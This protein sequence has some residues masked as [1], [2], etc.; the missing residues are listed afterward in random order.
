[1]DGAP[2]GGGLRWLRAGY[3]AA[4]GSMLAAGGHLF[5]GG[6]LPGPG[7]LVALA[8]LV[9]WPLSLFLGRR[10][11]SRQ[12]LLLLLGAQCAMHVG[13]SLARWY[14]HA[15]SLAIVPVTHGT[16][17]HGGAAAAQVP[18]AWS[19]TGSMSHD[20][21][22]SIL[23]LAV[24]DLSQGH[25][26]TMVAAHLVGAA[27]MWWWLTRAEL[28]VFTLL[29]LSVQPAGIAVREVAGPL[30]VLLSLSRRAFEDPSPGLRMFRA[31]V[32]VAPRLPFWPDAGRHV[33]ARRGPPSP[34]PT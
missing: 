6:E 11:S 34:Q 27:L 20:M 14:D 32:D 19:S 9:A 18:G 33:V 17:H 4:S 7:V 29:S 10:A 1:M 23:D 8:A 30:R 22:G 5:A 26:V 13:F 16:H 12:I 2:V 24:I 21:G 3:L 25:D 15:S 28:A 31:C